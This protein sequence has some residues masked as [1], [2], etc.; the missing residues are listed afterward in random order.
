MAIERTLS[1]IKPDAVAKN[2]IGEIYGRFEKAGLKIVAAKML[3]LNDESAGGFYADVPVCLGVACAENEFL[4]SLGWRL[5]RQVIEQVP[6]SIG[7]HRHHDDNHCQQQQPSLRALPLLA[8]PTA[9][10]GTHDD[11]HSQPD[12][13]GQAEARRHQVAEIGNADPLRP[14]GSLAGAG[15]DEND[16]RGQRRRDQPSPWIEP[17]HHRPQRGHDSR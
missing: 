17:E 7:E 1:I 5:L 8:R 9:Q 15:Y 14:P 11:E 10:V 4:L 2:V 6:T 13:C 3:Q 16:P 12:Q